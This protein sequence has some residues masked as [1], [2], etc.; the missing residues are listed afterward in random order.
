MPTT[1]PRVLVTGV[2]GFIASWVAYAALKVGYRVR[3]TVRSLANESRISHLHDLCPG[4]KHKLELVE[5]DLT[6]DAGWAEAVH[7]CQ[8]IIH[9]ASPFCV[10]EPDDPNELIIPAVEGTLRVLRAAASQDI[11]PRRVIITS[12][13]AAV[14]LGHN[15]AFYSDDDW[16][17]LDNPKIPITT[18]PRSKT[19]AESA[20]WKFVE[21]LPAD[22]RFELAAVNPS[23]VLGPMLSSNS[24]YAGETV[25]K[26]LLAQYPALPDIRFNKVSV[27]DV[28]RAH[29][30]AM[31]HPL[32]AGKRFVVSASSSGVR[33][34]STVIN[35]EFRQHGYKPVTVHS[36]NFM[37]QVIASA[38]DREAK[39]SVPML[40]KE[41]NFRCENA[42]TILGLTFAEEF[43][44]I[45]EMTLAVIAHGLVPDKSPNQRLTKSYR[46][47]EFD[48]SMIP[49]A[50]IE[51]FDD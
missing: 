23:A 32:A 14:S 11:L 40:A 8:Y 51:D 17:V 42:R 13:V 16:T 2:S 3:G 10:K 6:S 35:R 49:N 50:V 43:D 25:A 18:Y 5:A 31:T 20:A 33:E 1:E 21:S 48:T 28:A 36:P 34:Y 30:L 4:S 44:L 12:S 29:L 41:D 22:R 19:L 45:K 15:K 39:G 7:G 38:G 24:C 37:L 9:V 47:P 46:C 26:V 27:F